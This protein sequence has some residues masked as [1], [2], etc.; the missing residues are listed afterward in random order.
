MCVPAF[1]TGKR[2]RCVCDCVYEIVCGC[3]FVIV[4]VWDCVWLCVW[5]FVTVRLCVTG[6]V[7]EIVYDCVC[8]CVWLCVWDC[9]CEREG[10]YGKVEWEGRREE[11][12]MTTKGHICAYVSGWYFVS[13][14]AIRIGPKRNFASFFSACK[15]VFRCSV[16]AR[17][18]STQICEQGRGE[19]A[20]GPP[21]GLT[22]AGGSWSCFRE[23]WLP[24]AVGE[25]GLA[26]RA[27]EHWRASGTS[28]CSSGRFPT[29][30]GIPTLCI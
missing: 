7:C 18:P 27:L 14:K 1:L 6:C 29:V 23:P 22:C 10:D 8:D 26:S 16:P 4:C 9:V 30:V 19:A 17:K 11:S 12:K 28:E 20:G 24:A 21:G 3:V 15:L 2:S 5:L 25:A 13:E